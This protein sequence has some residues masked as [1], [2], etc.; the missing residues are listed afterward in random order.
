MEQ[1]DREAMRLAIETLL[2]LEPDWRDQVAAM[3]Q[4][5][6]WEQVGAFAAGVCQVRSLQLKPWECPPC[7]TANVKE[8]SD[9]Y[10]S[11]PGEVALLRKMLSFGLSRYDPNPLK[12]L[13]AAEAKPAA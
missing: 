3:L 9:N 4:A 13:A 2:R 12:A 1:R 7:D 8:P 6:P 11:R 5:Q 10:G